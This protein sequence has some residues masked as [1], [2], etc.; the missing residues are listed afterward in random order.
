MSPTI[1]AVNAGSSSLK[2]KVFNAH[3]MEMIWAGKAMGIG[4]ISGSHVTDENGH[5]VVSK[6][7]RDTSEPQVIE[8]LINWIDEKELIIQGI[9]HRVVHGVHVFLSLQ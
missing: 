5:D 9:G 2:F 6:K 3:T 4:S 8:M 7:L 1:L